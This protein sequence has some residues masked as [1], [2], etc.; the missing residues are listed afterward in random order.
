MINNLS[1]LG[2]EAEI[3]VRIML[4][5][6]LGGVVGFE[7][8]RR[9]RPAGLRTFMLV[10]IGSALFTVVGI[11]GFPNPGSGTS[12]PSRIA[13][14]IVT[15][16]G[17][18]GGGMLIK[19]GASIR[20]LTTSAGIWTVSAIGLTCGVGMY[21]LAIFSTIVV[22]VVLAVIRYFEP[23]RDLEEED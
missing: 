20:G 12:D 14:Q 17:F 8:E 23:D 15:G 21:G 18:L 16:I 4:A 7:R 11:Y 9:R 6:V 2:P 13:A 22:T 19:T 5:A 3:A 10:A 1:F